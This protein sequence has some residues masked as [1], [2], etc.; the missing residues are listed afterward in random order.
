[1]SILCS[2]L[3]LSISFIITREHID[4]L[5]FLYSNLEII[6]LA[7]VLWIVCVSYNLFWH[8]FI[9][10]HGHQI[11]WVP[12]LFQDEL[13]ENGL[14]FMQKVQKSP[15]P[16]LLSI[17]VVHIKLLSIMLFI[18]LTVYIGI[19]VFSNQISWTLMN[20]DQI[21]GLKP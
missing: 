19:S 14:V 20:F 1:M 2:L 7:C 18:E 11:H 12:S 21:Y 8:F 5:R 16:Y 15:T 13:F 4:N 9:V 10:I 6:L 3:N 17:N